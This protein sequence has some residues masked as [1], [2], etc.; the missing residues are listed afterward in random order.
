MASKYTDEQWIERFREQ[1]DDSGGCWLWTG[2][3]SP[4]TISG[5]KSGRLWK[6]LT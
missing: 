4:T 1:V 3:R 6:Y 5:I 2:P